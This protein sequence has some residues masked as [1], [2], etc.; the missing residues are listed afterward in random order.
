MLEA[1]HHDPNEGDAAQQSR[2]AELPPSQLA[3]SPSPYRVDLDLVDVPYLA[4]NAGVEGVLRGPEAY[5]IYPSVEGYIAL[6]ESCTGTY[7]V[8]LVSTGTPV[9]RRYE[10]DTT[11][12]GSLTVFFPA[13]ELSLF[14]LMPGATGGEFGTMET[15]GAP[16]A[17][18]ESAGGLTLASGAVPTD[19]IGI[20]AREINIDG[21]A[22]ASLAARPRVSAGQQYSI[23]WHLT[24]TQQVNRQ[25]QIRLRARSVKFGW[26]QRFEIGGARGTGAGGTYPL[27]TNNSIAQEALPGIGGANPDRR[28]PGEPGG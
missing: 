23:R 11:E 4:A 9:M 5:A 3:T 27:N 22:V 17:D 13:G 26:R 15:T 10:T 24:S 25:A 1:F 19:R 12:A 7:L 21:A 2:L 18:S 16:P 20:A 6:T 8:A 28:A 14:I